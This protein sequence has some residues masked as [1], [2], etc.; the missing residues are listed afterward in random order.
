MTGSWEIGASIGFTE[1]FVKIGFYYLHERIWLKCP[2]GRK[3]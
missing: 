1:F 3:Q 2:W